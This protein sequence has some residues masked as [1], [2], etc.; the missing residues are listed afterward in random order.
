MK[1]KVSKGMSAARKF[2][3]DQ[4]IVREAQE[5]SSA[6]RYI[7]ASRDT[8]VAWMRRDQALTL[9]DIECGTVSPPNNAK[10]LQVV[11]NRLD[12]VLAVLRRAP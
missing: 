5:K 12:E 6:I 4:R 8:K 9:L 2:D 1:K 7:M 10:A 3:E 11:I